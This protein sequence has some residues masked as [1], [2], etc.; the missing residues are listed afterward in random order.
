MTL[1]DARL[2]AAHAGKPPGASDAVDGNQKALRLY[3][4]GDR[5][6]EV[7]MAYFERAAVLLRA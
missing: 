1:S 2:R 7:V 4:S 6:S 3:L 5:E